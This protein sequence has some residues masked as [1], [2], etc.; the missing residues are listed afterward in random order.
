ME[1]QELLRELRDS[2]LTIRVEGNNLVISPAR[3]LTQSQRE[4]I[5]RFKPEILNEVTRPSPTMPPCSDWRSYR[6]LGARLGDQVTVGG[7]RYELWGVTPRGAI[8]WDGY[9]LRTFEP[10]VVT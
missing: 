8:C 3:E 4:R 9:S 7:A 1:A 10:E 2:G 5:R 6:I